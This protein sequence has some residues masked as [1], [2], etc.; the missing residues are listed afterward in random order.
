LERIELH[1]GFSK[2]D[3]VGVGKVLVY[4]LGWLYFSI[5]RCVVS[6]ISV[7]YGEYTLLS[8]LVAACISSPA[9]DSLLHIE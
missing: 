5:M 6:H 1:V 2:I 8:G 4:F 7:P 3:L 9:N